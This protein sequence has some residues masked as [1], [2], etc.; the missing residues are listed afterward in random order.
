M[1]T[2]VSR[3]AIT[4]TPCKSNQ[5]AATGYDPATKTMALQFLRGSGAQRGP[6]SIYH[7]ANVEPQQYEALTK[8]ESI[9]KHFGVHFKANAAHPYTKIEEPLKAS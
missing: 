1:E 6:G 5:I 8:A 4:L 2:T 7:Y 3:P 9:G